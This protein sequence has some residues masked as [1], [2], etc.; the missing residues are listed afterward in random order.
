MPAVAVIITK[1]Y[2][3]CSASSAVVAAVVAVAVVAASASDTDVRNGSG[4]NSEYN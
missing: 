4:K 2:V 3:Q 1:Q